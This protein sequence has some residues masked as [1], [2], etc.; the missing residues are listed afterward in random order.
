MVLC[1]PHGPPAWYYAAMPKM[2]EGRR[3]DL[4]WEDPFKYA[5][6]LRESGECQVYF[7]YTNLHRKKIDPRAFMRQHFHGMPWK[8][9]VSAENFTYLIDYRCGENEHRGSWPNWQASDFNL[10]ELQDLI[11]TPWSERE[12]LP[13]VPWYEVPIP[14][15]QHRIFIRDLKT[16]NDELTKN[17]RRRMTKIQRMFP[18]VELFI[19]PAQFSMGLMFGAGFSAGC[20]DPYRERGLRK[21]AIYLP[22]GKRVAIISTLAYRDKIEYFGFDPEEVKYDQDVGLLYTIASIRYAAHHWDD[23]TGPFSSKSRAFSQ[24]DYQNPDMYAGMPSYQ[25]INN[26]RGEKA[27]DTDKIL[28]DSCSLWRLCPAYRT[29]AVC[30]LPSS[31]SKRLSELALSR[32]ADDVVEMLASI[33]SKQAERVETKIDDE[34]FLESGHDKDIDKMLNSLF[35]NGT[36]LAK[37]RDPSLGRAPLVQINAGAPQARQVAQADPR[38]LA[39]TVIEEIEAS[40]VRREDITEQMIEDHLRGYATQHQLEGE[41]VDAEVADE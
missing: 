3:Y 30:G 36:Q 39:A 14:T 27:K 10:R 8:C 5:N 38:A 35:K 6:H 19:K 29:E 37:L 34:K 11:E 23:P 15:Q 32:N 7:T 40:G 4:W 24:P 13:N 2:H 9:Y 18:E 22:S 41:V 12:V 25:V 16:G 33:V 20:L 21:G 28:C 17:R 1:S 26:F 31:E